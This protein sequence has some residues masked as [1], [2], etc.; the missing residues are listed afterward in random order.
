VGGVVLF[1]QTGGPFIGGR[2]RE[3]RWLTVGVRWRATVAAGRGGFG[4]V[5]RGEVTV[6]R[7]CRRA[8]ARSRGSVS[9]REAEGKERG[10][11][12]FPLFLPGLKGGVRAGEAGDR[13]HGALHVRR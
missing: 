12:P 6:S 7:H 13:Q 10:S 11:G 1:R 4:S 5:R 9:C 2:G 8:L 3:R